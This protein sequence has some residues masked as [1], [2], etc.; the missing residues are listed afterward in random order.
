MFFCSK[1]N[2]KAHTFSSVPQPYCALL[3]TGNHLK[4]AS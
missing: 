1:Q 2:F 4:P 3:L